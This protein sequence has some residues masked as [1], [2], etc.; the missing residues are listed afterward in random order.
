MI[1]FGCNDSRK[2]SFCILQEKL[3]FLFLKFSKWSPRI[4]SI[5][6]KQIALKL[7]EKSFLKNINKCLSFIT[8]TWSM[9]ISL[10]IKFGSG[11]PE[12]YGSIFSNISSKSLLISLTDR[13]ESKNY[14]L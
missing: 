2:W 3:K 8:L 11:L 1:I 12:P 10:I 14:N 13:I 6:L 4:V 9:L 5:Q 7:V